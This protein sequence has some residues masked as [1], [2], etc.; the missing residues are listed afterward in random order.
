MLFL[1]KGKLDRAL[2]VSNNQV[3]N[4]KEKLLQLL[5]NYR[6]TSSTQVV[7]RSITTRVRDAS[8]R[9]A[10]QTLGGQLLDSRLLYSPLHI[11]FKFRIFL[12]KPGAIRSN[13]TSYIRE[14]SLL[15][16]LVYYALS[17]FWG[18]EPEIHKVVINSK[19][20]FIQL[21]LFY[22]L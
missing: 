16:P 17:Y 20:I 10:L 9:V 1:L 21:N 11:D 14:F 12:L 22:A 6:A 8:A 4:E 15:H 3:I 13:I 18:L 7:S 19:A 5:P 2:V